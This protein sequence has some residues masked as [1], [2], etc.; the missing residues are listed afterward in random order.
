MYKSS[1]ADMMEGMD[2]LGICS[3]LSFT[4]FC[5]YFLDGGTHIEPTRGAR[6]RQFTM[7]WIL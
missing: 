4:A 3:R 7:Y 1:L 2:G 6:Q 5:P